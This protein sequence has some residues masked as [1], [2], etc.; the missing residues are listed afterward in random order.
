MPDQ[1]C[2]LSHNAP[3][4]RRTSDRAATK[5]QTI[6]KTITGFKK[7]KGHTRGFSV[8]M[9]KEYGDGDYTADEI[10]EYMG[11]GTYVLSSSPNY[12]PLKS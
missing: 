2:D 9:A 3:I 8:A 11:L 6:W 10:I 12:S 5:T 4:Q 7:A 1:L